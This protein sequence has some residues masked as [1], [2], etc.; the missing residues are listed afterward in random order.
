MRRA[1]AK[2][3]LRGV[4]HTGGEQHPLPPN[5]CT[6]AQLCVR[7]DS[8][9]PSRRKATQRCEGNT[10]LAEYMDHTVRS[11]CLGKDCKATACKPLG[12]G[13][14][15]CASQ[16]QECEGA[17]PGLRLKE[18]RGGGGACPANRSCQLRSNRILPTPTAATPILCAP[19]DA[20][21][22]S[23]AIAFRLRC[24]GGVAAVVRAIVQALERRGRA[25]PA[26]AAV[27]T[28]G[29]TGVTTGAAAGGRCHPRSGTHC[30][31][32]LAAIPSDLPFL[33]TPGMVRKRWMR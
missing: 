33:P 13:G 9:S 31:Q 4:Q 16:G 7:M 32:E 20:P 12:H 17:H 25:Q 28:V 22:P 3:Q 21:P 19:P 30:V 18:G 6:Q 8:G 14:T 5:A 27:R 1:A 2:R 29:S 11:C 23:R 15:E 10:E 26:G 24:S